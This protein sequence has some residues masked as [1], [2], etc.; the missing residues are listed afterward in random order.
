MASRGW[1][2]QVPNQLLLRVLK[3]SV[4]VLPL[5]VAGSDNLLMEGIGGFMAS[6]KGVV[7]P[8]A[9]QST[10]PPPAPM[11]GLPGLS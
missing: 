10:P 7:P 11:A 5:G 3:V 2:Y 8:K 6:L 9:P 4:M 1:L